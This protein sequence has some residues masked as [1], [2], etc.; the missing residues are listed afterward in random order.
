MSDEHTDEQITFDVDGVALEFPLERATKI[1]R[2][3]NAA[4]ARHVRAKHEAEGLDQPPKDH[5]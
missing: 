1:A 2:A 5:A 4:V 3:L